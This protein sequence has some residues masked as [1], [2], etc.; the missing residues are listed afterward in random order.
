MIWLILSLVS[1]ALVGYCVLQAP[2][3]E[4]EVEYPL[5]KIEFLVEH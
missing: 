5:E 3:F 1:F 2:E 4:E